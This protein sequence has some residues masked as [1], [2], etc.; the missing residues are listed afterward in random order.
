MQFD[1]LDSDKDG[2]LTGVDL[3]NAFTASG[4]G[5][6]QASSLASIII[7]QLDTNR[8]N[9]ISFTQ[10]VEARLKYDLSNRPRDIYNDILNISNN[11]LDNNELH[12]VDLNSSLNKKIEAA[13]DSENSLNSTNIHCLNNDQGISSQDIIIFSKSQNNFDISQN[14]LLQIF[15]KYGDGNGKLS[16][17]DFVCAVHSQRVVD[18]PVINDNDH[19]LPK[20]KRFH[21]KHGQLPKTNSHQQQIRD[22]QIWSDH[23][24]TTYKLSLQQSV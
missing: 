11:K 2:F 17:D 13:F 8:C 6:N 9:K 7:N 24:K 16:Y 21:S 3:I 18:A 14:D 23:D 12:K 20:G 1:K 15:E 4:I 10:F 19:L 5:P 22:N